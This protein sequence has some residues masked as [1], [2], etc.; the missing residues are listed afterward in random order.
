MKINWVNFLS[1]GA[2]CFGI[3][4]GLQIIFN[5]LNSSTTNQNAIDDLLKGPLIG[6]IPTIILTSIAAPMA[7][8]LA[9]REGIFSVFGNRNK[10]L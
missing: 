4:Y 9:S 10:E 7:E 2:F 5:V 1:I 6:V 3:A 8:E